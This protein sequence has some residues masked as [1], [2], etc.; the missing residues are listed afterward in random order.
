MGAGSHLKPEI[1]VARAITEAAQS[2]VVQIQGAR[3][4]TDRE[5]LSEVW[6]TTA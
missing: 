3:E 6:D 5:V 1:A 4:D 2:R